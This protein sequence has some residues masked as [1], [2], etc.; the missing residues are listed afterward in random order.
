LSQD[1]WPAQYLLRFDD[2]CPTMDRGCWERFPPLL[3]RFGI[4]PILAVVPE[5]HDPDLKRGAPHEGFWEEM[6]ALEA[7]GATIGL[8]GYR[9]DCT[10]AGRSLIP[11]HAKT[12]FAG[13]DRQTQREWIRAGLTILRSQRLRP[14]MWVAPRHGLDLATLAVLRE[15]GVGVISDGFAARPFREHGLIWI[16]QQLWG[17][18][19]K[20]SGLWTICLHANAVTDQ[21]VFGLEQ[22]LKRCGPRFTSVDRV[23][24]EWPIGERSLGDRLFHERTVMRI[25][26]SRTIRRWRKA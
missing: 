25:R 4:R 26:W 22:F 7:G 15:E 3:A 13:V 23:L 2:L 18:M 12:E 1:S 8:H 14:Q 6:R 16:P 10:A 19:E 21:A 9:H 20:K 11:V 17:P 5:N 24:A